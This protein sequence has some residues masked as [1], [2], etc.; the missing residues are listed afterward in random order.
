MMKKNLSSSGVLS[1]VRELSFLYTLLGF[2]VIFV[3]SSFLSPS[4]LKVSNI[5]TILRQAGLLVIL[6]MGLTA[7]VIT[8]NI[9]LSVAHCAALTGCICAKMMT[10]GYSIPVSILASLLVGV[11]TGLFNGVLVGVLNLP[12]FIASYGTRMVLSGLAIIV[13][14]GGVI[15]G[16]DEKFQYL[17]NGYV[18]PVPFLVILAAVMVAILAFVYYKTTYGRQLYMYGSNHMA[19]KYS[20]MNTLFI[21]ISAY[22][23][24]GLCASIGGVILAARANAADST[25]ASPYVLQTVA[26]VVVG[27]TSLLGGEGGV[28]GTVIGSLVLV[29]I[30]NIMNILMIDSNWQ[31]LVIGISILLMVWIDVST[32]KSRMK[33]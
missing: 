22:V 14:N 4:F 28:I 33:K 25:M 24:S 2:L 15:Y 11:V 7:V 5:L 13:M 10:S 16:L 23:L 19:A 18:G 17:A 6:S 3:I 27:G 1:R 31:N 30:T 32:R 26:A 20:G 12:S 29:M 8:G 9:D 21:L